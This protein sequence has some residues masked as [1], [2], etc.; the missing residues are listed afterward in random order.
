MAS[1][2]AIFCVEELI[3]FKQISTSILELLNVAV[4]QRLALLHRK[5]RA[6]AKCRTAFDRQP[7]FFKSY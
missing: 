6:F 4:R 5:T 3:P 7:E 2:R 1:R